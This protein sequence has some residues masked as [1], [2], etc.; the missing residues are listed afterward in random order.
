[1]I[2][3][4]IGIVTLVVLILM[5]EH[6]RHIDEMNDAYY[7]GFKDGSRYEKFLQNKKD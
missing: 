3:I 7:N 1:M 4:S 6:R 2:Y 5:V